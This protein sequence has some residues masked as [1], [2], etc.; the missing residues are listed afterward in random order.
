ML[1][2]NN[3]DMSNLSNKIQLNPISKATY[4]Q[5]HKIIINSI[6]EKKGT[7][8]TKWTIKLNVYQKGASSL[9]NISG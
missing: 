3:E 2:K 7:S 8:K 6:Q 4:G 9:Q 5:Q 1:P